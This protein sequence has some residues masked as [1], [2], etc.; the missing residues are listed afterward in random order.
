MR[1]RYRATVEFETDYSF[2]EGVYEQAVLQAVQGTLRIHGDRAPLGTSHRIVSLKAAP[3]E[4]Q[5]VGFRPR[6]T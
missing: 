1:Y 4:W 2:P 5:P 3:S 6:D